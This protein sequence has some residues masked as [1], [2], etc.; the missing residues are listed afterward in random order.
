MENDQYFIL[1]VNF[2]SDDAIIGM[3][4]TIEASEALGIYVALLTYLRAKDNYEASFDTIHVEAIARIYRFNP[5]MVQRVIV[6][7]GIFSL[8]MEK[9]IFRSPYLD[10]VMEKLQKRR[11]RDSENGK[12][13]GRPRNV[14]NPSKMAAATGKRPDEKSGEKQKSKVEK[15]RTITTVEY[16]SS[17]SNRKEETAAAVVVPLELTPQPAIANIAPSLEPVRPWESLV[18]EM[19]TCQE[20]LCIVASHSGLGKQFIENQPRI[21]ALFKQHIRLYAKEGDLLGLK[22]VKQYFSNY[23]AMGSVTVQKLRE[24]LLEDAKAVYRQNPYRYETVE[25][26]RRMCHGRVIPDGAPPRPDHLSAWDER[27]GKWVR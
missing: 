7:F 24:V 11:Q 14:D 25:H 8:D 2:M 5:E 15:S 27:Y 16:N 18:D 9:K 3:M 17:N 21:L 19:G 23:M 22:N 12:K 20:Y 1:E 13:G 10:R 26:G 4:Q 6:D